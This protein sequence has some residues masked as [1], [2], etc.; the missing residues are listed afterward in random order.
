MDTG[1]KHPVS[2]KGEP[3]FVIFDLRTLW[4]TVLS[5]E[6]QECPHVKNYK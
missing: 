3:S 4:R 5:A 1:I 6:R 2:D